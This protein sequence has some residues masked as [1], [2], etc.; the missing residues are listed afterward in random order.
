MKFVQQ[1]HKQTKI[2]DTCES[3][4]ESGQMPGHEQYHYR[5]LFGFCREFRVIEP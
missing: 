3:D 1:N 2:P 5:K 4:R